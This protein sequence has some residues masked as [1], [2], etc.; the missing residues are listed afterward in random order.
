MS[1]ADLHTHT[2]YSDGEWPPAK[3]VRAAVHAGLSGL[4]ITDHDD[5]RAFPEAEEAGAE[6]GV[7]ILSGTELSTWW[8]ET[9]VHLLAYGF[10]PGHAELGE[11]LQRARHG[12]RNRAERMTQR[13]TELGV[14]VSMERVL[15]IAGTGSI[16]RPHVARALVEAGHVPTMR[17]AFDLYL[18][19]GKPACL[20]KPRLAPEEAVRIVHAA[21]GVV[22]V[23]HPVVLGGAEPLE[24]LVDTGVDGVE[25]RHT[26][27]GE[28][29]ER[30]F[31]DFARAH[32]MLRTG[33]SD[34]HG[35]R[36]G[37]PGVGAVSVPQEWWEE[38]MDAVDSSRRAAASREGGDHAG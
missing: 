24:R 2:H 37:G 15:A 18:G 9:D 12:R 32:G 13:L 7:R 31:H 21:G 22:S 23:A 25:V 19:D 26:L 6:H 10:D 34:F 11:V 3:V 30:V 14:G 4:A 17:A 20:E 1:F 35:P 33:G 5:V 8:E 28:K 36:P 38:L 27:H 29:A 16:G